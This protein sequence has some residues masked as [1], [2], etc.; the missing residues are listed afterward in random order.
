MKFF[1]IPLPSKREVIHDLA[2]SLA[3]G[4]GGTIGFAVG[5]ILAGPKGAIWGSRIGSTTA[6]YLI[7]EAALALDSELRYQG[8][9]VFDPRAGWTM[10]RWMDSLRARAMESN[11]QLRNAQFQGTL[12][13]AVHGHNPVPMLTFA[14]APPMPLISID[15][16]DH[17]KP[18]IKCKKGYHRVGLRCIKDSV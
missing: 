2:G 17:L 7:E 8:G 16:V 3:S 6:P 13:A 9:G 1:G 12:S 11:P 4:A 10:D 5:G 15:D 18:P 14:T